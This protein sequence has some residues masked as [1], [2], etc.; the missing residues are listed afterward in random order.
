MGTAL[1]PFYEA[2]HSKTKVFVKYGSARIGFMHTSSFNAWKD[3]ST[4]G[5]QVKALF[6]RRAMRGVAIFS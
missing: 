4:I 2:S 1:I 3:W 5:F 6:L